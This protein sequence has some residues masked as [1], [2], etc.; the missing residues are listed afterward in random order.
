LADKIFNLIIISMCVSTISITLTKGRPFS[1]LRNW[2]FKR[3][4][5]LGSLLSCTYC[6]SHWAAIVIVILVYIYNPIVFITNILFID[7]II[8]IF[9]IVSI[10]TIITGIIKRL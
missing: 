4:E 5:W 8:T 7:A 9:A 2:A 1:F 10:S 6:M 3:S